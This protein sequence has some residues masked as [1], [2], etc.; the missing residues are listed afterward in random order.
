M[1]LIDTAL[2]RELSARA[3]SSPRRRANF[4]LHHDLEDPVQRFLN[5]VEPGSYVCPH[6]HHMPPR[7][8]LFAAIE[9]RAAVLLF[10]PDGEVTERTEVTTGGGIRVAEIPAGAWHTLVA[11]QPGTVLLEIK[12]GPYTPHTEESLASWAPREGDPA[13]VEAERWFRTARP[14]DAFGR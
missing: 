12:Q 10:A 4:N 3:A 8:E 11:L 1:K 13:C 6:R 7:H 2:L 5:A 14:G 9:G